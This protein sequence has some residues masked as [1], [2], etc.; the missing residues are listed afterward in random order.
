V[1]APSTPRLR[2]LRRVWESLESPQEGGVLVGALA[3]ALAADDSLPPLLLGAAAATTRRDDAGGALRAAL[4]A[5][6][7][8]ANSG[9]GGGSDCDDDALSWGEFAAAFGGAA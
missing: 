1:A 9:G 4:R 8:A 5:A 2:A 3:N 7:G 6:R